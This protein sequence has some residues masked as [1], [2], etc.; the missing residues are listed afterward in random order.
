M[1]GALSGVARMAG[2][3]QALPALWSLS[4]SRAFLL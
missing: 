3:G 4:F 1:S 2:I